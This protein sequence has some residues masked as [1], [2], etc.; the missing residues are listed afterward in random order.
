MPSRTPKVHGSGAGWSFLVDENMPRP[1][2]PALIG[3][4]YGAEDVR[5]VGLRGQGDGA[6]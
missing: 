2:A 3:A 4:G 5:D 1:L 6:V